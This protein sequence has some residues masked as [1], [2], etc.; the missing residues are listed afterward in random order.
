MR[1]ILDPVSIP[2]GG[3]WPDSDDQ[4][5]TELPAFSW[6]HVENRTAASDVYVF[7]GA[8]PQNADVT[9]QR[10]W[11]RVTGNTA[12]T[13]NCGG[14][15]AVGDEKGEDVLQKKL[16]IL[17]PGAAAVV[18]QIEIADAPIVDIQGPANNV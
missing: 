14:P 8:R 9:G 13:M 17:N 11:R 3:C 16:F 15:H 1:K 4:T 7:L 18:V 10:H 2:A 5:G 6:V 12:R